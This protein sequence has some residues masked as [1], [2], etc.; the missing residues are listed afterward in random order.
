MKLPNLPATIKQSSRT[1]QPPASVPALVENFCSFAS[2]ALEIVKRAPVMD[3]SGQAA[4][5]NTSLSPALVEMTPVDGATGRNA[6]QG[7][8]GEK[9]CAGRTAKENDP[10]AR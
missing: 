8:T 2:L 5:S 7:K 6:D 9:G 10:G 4:Q 3:L 1:T